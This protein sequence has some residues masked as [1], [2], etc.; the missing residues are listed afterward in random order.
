MRIGAFTLA[1]LVVA[2]FAGAAIS[3]FSKAQFTQYE[4]LGGWW[5]RAWNIVTFRIARRLAVPY[6]DRSHLACY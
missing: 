1:S 3:L 4:A 2:M 5:P 6:L